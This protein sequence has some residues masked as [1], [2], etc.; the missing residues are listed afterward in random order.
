MPS[1]A[2][3]AT[4][5]GNGAE[6]VM[7][8]TVMFPATSCRRALD[9]RNV[10]APAG[11]T[12]VEQPPSTPDSASVA[13]Q[14]TV[15]IVVT[16]SPSETPMIVTT[17]PVRS[18]SSV[19]VVDALF[20]ARSIAVPTIDCPAPSVETVTGSVQVSIPEANAPGSSQT[21]VTVGALLCQPAV[22]GAGATDAEIVGAVVSATATTSTTIDALD[23]SPD[24]SSIV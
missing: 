22:F 15:G 5:Q 9:R 18:M 8:S 14:L 24:G 4:P 2:A 10:F 12:V 13:E 7:V 21:N 11:V 3:E 23:V 19:T 16:P 20:P 17:G 1:R 6:K